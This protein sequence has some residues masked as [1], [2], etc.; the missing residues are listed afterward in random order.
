M[1]NKSLYIGVNRYIDKKYPEL[2]AV[3][4][5]VS[6]LNEV[7]ENYFP[8][9]SST[10]MIENENT[11]KENIET[12]ITN[13]LLNCNETD[14]LLLYWA[15]HGEIREIENGEKIGYFVLRDTR[16]D[17]INTGISMDF[18]SNLINTSRA[19]T[20]I[21]IFDTCH[22]GW[23]AR[24]NNSF[25]EYMNE[26]LK[27]TGTGIVILTA[28][29][30]TQKAYQTLDNK[31]GS[32][33]KALI[34]EIKFDVINSNP[35]SIFNLYYRVSQS[36][37]NFYSKIN[38]EQNPCINAR[39]EG[40][41]I[42]NI[43]DFQ[44]KHKISNLHQYSNYEDLKKSKELLRIF[45]RAYLKDKLHFREI[46]VESGNNDKLLPAGVARITHYSNQYYYFEINW[47]NWVIRSFLMPTI[48]GL[49]IYLTDNEVK[50]IYQ[51]G[52]NVNISI[53]INCIYDI[54]HID[55]IGFDAQIN[56]KKRLFGLKNLDSIKTIEL[57]E[58]I[59]LLLFINEEKV[60][61]LLDNHCVV[62]LDLLTDKKYN[63]QIQLNDTFNL[64][65]AKFSNNGS[66]LV[67]FV[68]INYIEKIVIY[69]FNGKEFHEFKVFETEEI[70]RGFC[71]INLH[72]KDSIVIL[73]KDKICIRDINNLSDY[74]KINLPR[75]PKK[76]LHG[77]F[78]SN[79]QL[80]INNSICYVLYKGK[81][82][83]INFETETISF[84]DIETKVKRIISIINDDYMLIEV[85]YGIVSYN[86]KT[87]KIR[88]VSNN[89]PR[90]C[91]GGSKECLYYIKEELGL[92]SILIENYHLNKTNNFSLYGLT[93][94][95]K[96]LKISPNG[97]YI[98]VGLE[99]GEI[100]IYR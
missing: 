77:L 96:D 53:K 8:S 99:N 57:G 40:D 7:L 100:R 71:F 26:F 14:N 61:V 50:K 95:V 45:D 30:K 75:P 20:V 33:T 78:T 5:D 63:Y 84:I 51:E 44:H 81:I 10:I 43:T 91:L 97:E 32:F 79:Y 80:E 59:L 16:R 73:Y 13:F 47:D 31:H 41:I 9:E 19:N 94:R 48:K 38:I 69:K 54:P 60:I 24:D 3:R 85:S 83:K 1:K 87:S 66:Y 74:K 67:L 55:Q 17:C 12:A 4:N 89:D 90:K 68:E 21:A 2:E 39:V 49:F 72:N 29:S 6:V 35:I 34:D 28:S 52:N 22:S 88:K 42:L 15:G 92:I 37:L 23:V 36:L 86:F 11:L 56:D 65:D 46:L 27:I 82:L 58:V 62:V 64:I 25:K 18:V 70:I 93:E 76:F 98:I